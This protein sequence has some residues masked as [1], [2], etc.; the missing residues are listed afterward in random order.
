VG[1]SY[2]SGH[3]CI[4][5]DANSL[6]EADRANGYSASGQTRWLQACARLIGLLGHFSER[7]HFPFGDIPENR[8]H[9]LLETQTKET[10]ATQRLL[11]IK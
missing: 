1:L 5:I 6:L 4:K 3:C 8:T 9:F 7:S 2:I 10:R 11:G